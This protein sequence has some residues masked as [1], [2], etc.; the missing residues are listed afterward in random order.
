M[1]DCH[2]AAINRFKC[3]NINMR[4]QILNTVQ[5]H[6]RTYKT[7]IKNDPGL[8]DWVEN[9][10][11]ARIDH[12]P[13]KIYSAVYQE[14]NICPRGNQKKFVTFS[15]GFAGC[16]RASVC[17]CAAETVSEK[18]SRAKSVYSDHTKQQISQKRQATVQ[19]RYGVKNVGQTLQAKQS[20]AQIYNNR[21]LVEQI[22]KQVKQTKLKRYNDANYNNADQIKQTFRQKRQQG[23]WINRYPHKAIADLEDCDRLRQLYQTLTPAEIADQLNVHIQT[24]YRYLNEHGLREPFKSADELELV[25]FIK[26]LGIENIVTNTR[27][28]L[29]SR[30]E[31][32]IVLP[33]HGVAIEYNGVYWHHE[34]VEHITR[35]YH[36]RKFKEA[37]SLGIQLI[38][39]FSN[40]W[41]SKKPI[42]KEMLRNKLNMHSG[43]TVYARKCRVAVID[44]G[45]ARQFLNQYHIQGHTPAP[46]HVAL[47]DRDQIVAVMSFGPTRAGIGKR[48]SDI[49]LIRFASAGRVVGG[50]S[51]LL[52]F[53]RSQN[54]TA[55]IISYSDNEW[56]TGHLYEKLGFDLHSEIKYSY[57]YLKPR[58][59]R[60]YHRYTFSKQKLVAQGHD[61]SMSESQI[62][63]SLG[64]LKVW[65]CGKRKWKLHPDG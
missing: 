45:R 52:K 40:F 62:T 43:H 2:F 49:E 25:R 26:Q 42:V 7:V 12:L 51:K 9:N 47:F 60:L 46:V 17:Q 10:T 41:H 29:P 5:Q 56:S 64:L 38:T 23:F 57:W 27:R 53:Y 48:S 34:D 35:D 30:K 39:V 15:R 54:P 18:V 28:V 4:E 16:G 3:I 55:T 58:E 13:T 32:D 36:Y 8:L 11:L 24:V 37:E 61:P 65:D 22:T 63:R 44:N 59:N 50:A 19:Q 33:D 20:R 14:S 21:D 1:F 31:L 6:P